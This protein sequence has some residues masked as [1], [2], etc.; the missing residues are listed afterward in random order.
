MVYLHRLAAGFEGRG[1]GEITE[2]NL[3]LL[4]VLGPDEPQPQE[5]TPESVLVV[6]GVLFPGGDALLVPCHVAESGDQV[7]VCLDLLSGGLAAEPGE[8]DRVGLHLDRQEVNAQGLADQPPL[9]GDEAVEVVE[10]LRGKAVRRHLNG[11]PI[12]RRRR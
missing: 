10:G 1:A 9:G 7:R 6:V 4:L 11:E 12:V 3:P 2:Q 5:E 8:G